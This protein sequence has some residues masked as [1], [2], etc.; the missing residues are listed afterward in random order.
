[1]KNFNVEKRKSGKPKPHFLLYVKYMFTGMH[2]E[3]ER[4]K[5]GQE[6][7]REIS[8]REGGDQKE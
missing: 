2:K 4:Q 3:M 7:I 6:S 8:W 5:W 1:M